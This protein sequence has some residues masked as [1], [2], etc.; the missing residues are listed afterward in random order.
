MKLTRSLPLLLLLAWP[1]VAPGAAS[2]AMTFFVTSRGVPGGA[3]LGG[4]AGADRHCQALAAAVGA[5]GRTWRAYLS[6][7][8]GTGP[9]IDARDRIGAGPWTNAK[10]VVIARD[11]EELHSDRN[12]LD[13]QTMLTERGELVRGDHDILT[14]SDPTGRLAFHDTGLPATCRDWTSSG[15]GVARVGHADRLDST[16]WGNARFPRLDGSWNSDHDSVGCSLKRLADSA[17]IGRI[18]CFSPSAPRAS[19]ARTPATP[20]APTSRPTFRR[21][22]NVNHWLGDNLRPD[23]LPNSHYGA[24]WFEEEDLAWIAARG[25]DHVRIRVNGALWVTKDGVLDEARLAPF[26]RALRGSRAHGLGVVLTMHGLPGFRAALFRGDPEPQGAASPFLDAA[27]RGDAAYLWWLIARRYVD[28]GDGLRFELLNT[29]DAPDPESMRTF[30]RACLR[31]IRRVSPRRM[32]YLTSYEM[33]LNSLRTIDLDDPYTAVSVDFWE[34]AVFAIQ[35]DEQRPLVRFP[36]RAPDL[37]KFAKD[38]DSAYWL[39]NTDLRPELL[40]ARLA[41]FARSAATWAGTHE[42]YI[43]AFGVRRRA[44]DTSARAYLRAVRAA[45]ERNNFA[46]AVYDYHTGGA[47]RDENGEPTRVLDGLGLRSK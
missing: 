39:S 14:G 44:D 34:P 2:T 41:A 45:F 16:H 23:M 47:V 32:V 8:P 9:S 22:V 3:N 13:R 1:A 42:I 27:T 26:D 30:N 28:E 10:G 17:G 21:G 33:T 11:L 25:F 15:E 35:H 6:A 5:G 18:Y 7:S 31:A 20:A 40:E 29:P 37:R 38:Q 36:G 19:T 4:L 24:P 43:S 12:R 46:W